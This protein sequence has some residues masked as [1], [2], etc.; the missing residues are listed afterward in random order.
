M[1]LREQMSRLSRHAVITALATAYPLVSSSKREGIFMWHH[2]RCGS[3]V[4]G[5]LLDQHPAIRWYG[6]IFE[7]YALRHARRTRF[8]DDLR[9]VQVASG[10]RAPGIEIKGLPCQH[11]PTLDVSLRR[12][13]EAIVA[14][15]FSRCIF[16]HRRNI[17]RK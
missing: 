16:L 13:V 9:Y 10:K 7:G 11:L 6:E 12:F 3:T 17:L 4:L 1:M 8:R 5:D 14:C 2:G 15:G